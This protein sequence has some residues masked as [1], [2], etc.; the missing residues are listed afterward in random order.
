MFSIRIEMNNWKFSGL[1]KNFR[2]DSYFSIRIQTGGVSLLRQRLKPRVQQSCSLKTCTHAILV[3]Y[4]QMPSGMRALIRVDVRDRCNSLKIRF[5]ILVVKLSSYIGQDA[6]ER[7]FSNVQPE[8]LANT[9]Q[10]S[11]NP[12]WRRHGWFLKKCPQ[13]YL[14]CSLR[15]VGGDEKK[16]AVFRS[17]FPKW[18][19]HH[20]EDWSQ[21]WRRPIRWR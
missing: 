7:P 4:C 6:W 16:S 11:S 9:H 19:L 12:L 10:L 18:S 14:N 13:F 17:V 3:T 8:R 1:S 5:F 20:W 2:L 21:R 15:E